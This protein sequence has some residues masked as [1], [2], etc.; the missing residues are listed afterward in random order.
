MTRVF[1]P[2]SVTLRSYFN[3]D[4]FDALLVEISQA[5]ISDIHMETNQPIWVRWHGKQMRLTNRPL[6]DQEIARVLN[7]IYGTSAAS[8]LAK[9]REI[10]KRHN[11]AISSDEIYAFRFNAITSRLTTGPA[12]RISLRSIPRDLPTVEDM[13][14]LDPQVREA[15]IHSRGIGF[16]V[17]ETGNGKSTLLAALNRSLLLDGDSRKLLT[18]EDPIEFDLT[19]LNEITPSSTVSQ[20][21]IGESCRSYYD[22][23]VNSLRSAPTDIMVGEAKERETVEAVLHSGETGHKTNATVH[24]GSVRETVLRL[25][26]EFPPDQQAG[27]VYKILSQVNFILV[28]KLVTRPGGGRR[29]PLRE[30]FVFDDATRRKLLAQSNTLS[31]LT[32]LDDMVRERG[33]DF[34]SQALRAYRSGSITSDAVRVFDLSFCEEAQ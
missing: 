6:T 4:E 19:P 7:H 20:H 16:V 28:Q 2:G 11:I 23:I 12:V 31:T 25:A 29:Y 17:G 9:I 33:Q 27:I 21:E 14:D 26:S 1:E 5:D 3:S 18:Y 13:V 24:A 32:M 10:H 34:Q 22:G 15:Y 30:W 8:E